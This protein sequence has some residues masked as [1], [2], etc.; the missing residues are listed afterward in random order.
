MRY[1][2][3]MKSLS[4]WKFQASEANRD[5]NLIFLCQTISIIKLGFCSGW[6]AGSIDVPALYISK[7][8]LNFISVTTV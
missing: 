3:E 7:K 5:T 8:M 2:N 4:K 6:Q 1:A